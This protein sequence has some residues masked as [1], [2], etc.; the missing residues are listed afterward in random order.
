MNARRPRTQRARVGG[1][2]RASAK[3]DGEE[4]SHQEPQQ[5]TKC[6]VKKE[7]GEKKEKS[8]NKIM[9]QE[10]KSLKLGAIT[11]ETEQQEETPESGHRCFTSQQHFAEQ[12]N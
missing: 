11:G 1:L 9:D 5:P 4:L 6:L 2:T 7:G 10:A 8:P 12:R 3:E